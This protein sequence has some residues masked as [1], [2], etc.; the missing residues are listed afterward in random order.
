MNTRKKKEPGKEV[1][2]A[3][4]TQC[5]ESSIVTYGRNVPETYHLGDM[6]LNVL[7]RLFLFQD[8][9]LVTDF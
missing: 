7:V 6:L 3:M 4:L 9:M 8:K 5:K 2:L 1:V